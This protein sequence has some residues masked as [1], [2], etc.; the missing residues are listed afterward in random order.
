MHLKQQISTDA[1]ANE[2]DQVLSLGLNF[3]L[4]ASRRLLQWLAQGYCQLSS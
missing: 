3:D 1:D 2:V 4:V